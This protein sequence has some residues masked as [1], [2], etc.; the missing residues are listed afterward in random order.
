MRGGITTSRVHA[1]NI[2]EFRA[3]ARFRV[4]A[5]MVFRIH[6]GRGHTLEGLFNLHEALEKWN[7]SAAKETGWF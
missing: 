4:E 5:L 1:G 6:L 7:Q 2:P 3:L